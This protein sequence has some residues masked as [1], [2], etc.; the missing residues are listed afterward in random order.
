MSLSSQCIRVS[1]VCNTEFRLLVILGDESIRLVRL[2][3]QVKTSFYNKRF[4]FVT[5]YLSRQA[6][7]SVFELAVSSCA[8][9]TRLKHTSIHSVE[10]GESFKPQSKAIGHTRSLQRVFFLVSVN[11]FLS[12]T[13]KPF[14][15]PV[16]TGSQFL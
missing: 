7:T 3:L 12:R 5:I 16:K 11:N 13:C 15:K 8:F 14:H 1:N 2:C 6:L 10:Q 9:I 4:Y